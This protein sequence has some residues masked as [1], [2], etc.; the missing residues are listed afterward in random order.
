MKEIFKQ[1]GYNL[2]GAAME[3]YNQMG[4]GFLEEIYQECLEI[5]LK[6]RGIVYESKPK[7]VIFYKKNR[8]NKYYQPDLYVY[9]GIIVELKAIKHLGD[10]EIA[11]ILNYLKGSEKRVGY[12]INYGCPTELEWKRFIL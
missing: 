10:N 1:E 2:I 11:Q 4:S 12:L 5:E 9:N 7:L 8:L 3:V 6:L